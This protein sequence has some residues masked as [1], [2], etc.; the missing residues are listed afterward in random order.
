VYQ[1]ALSSPVATDAWPSAL[2]RVLSRPQQIRVEYQPVVDLRRASI[3]G[4]EALARFSHTP[5]VAPRAWFDAAARLGCAGA[6]EA[7]VMQ[8]A[9]VAQPLLV[10]DRFIAVNVSPAALL[11]AEVQAVLGAEGNLRRVVVEI[12]ERTDGADPR[13]LRRATDALHVAGAAI[14]VHDAGSGLRSLD[15]VVTLRPRYI[16]ISGSVVRGVEH[17]PT[18][19]TMIR[20]LSEL[21][22]K[23]DARLI[24]QGIETEAQLDALVGLGVPFGQGFALG[25][26]ASALVELHP[27]VRARIQR[28]RSSDALTLGSLTEHAPDPPAAA[29]RLAASTPL[30]EAARRAMA[31]PPA[32]RFDPI[33]VDAQGAESGVVP[34]ERLVG[35]LAR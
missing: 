32:T 5:H 17:D 30:G 12:S 21:A 34:V 4:Y 9:L 16:K 2:E 23:L 7:Q 31:R 35:A 26:P 10:R 22:T 19:I 20:A 13:A 3:C 25:R 24:A 29:L 27:D 11:S 28:A 1:P 6:L 14:A 15:R 18:R 33:V 8:A